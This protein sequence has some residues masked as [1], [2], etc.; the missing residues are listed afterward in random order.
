MACCPRELDEIKVQRILGNLLNNAVEAMP[1]QNPRI[2]VTLSSRKGK[3]LIQIRDNGYGIAADVLP[4][5]MREGASFGKA[6]SS[7]LGLYDARITPLGIGGD[8]LISSSP[9]IG[10][11]GVVVLPETC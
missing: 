1:G 8:L 3:S 2:E 9:G 6:K 10:T 4:Q 11:E 5:L 7:G